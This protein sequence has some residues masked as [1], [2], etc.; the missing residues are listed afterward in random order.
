MSRLLF[1]ILS[2]VLTACSSQNIRTPAESELTSSLFNQP[3]A[4]LLA[5]NGKAGDTLGWAVSLSGRTALIGASQADQKGANAGAA[6]FFLRTD[7]IWT[8]HQFVTAS[9]GRAGDRFGMAVAVASSTAVVGAPSADGVTTDSGAVYIFQS[10][11]GVWR[12]VQKIRASDGASGDQFGYSVSISGDFIVVGA[13]QDDGKGSAYVFRRSNNTWSQFKK[14]APTTLKPNDRFGRSTLVR[15]NDIMIGSPGDSERGNGAG[16][17]YVYA[18]T[19]SDWSGEKKLTASLAKAGDR[20]GRYMSISGDYAVIG[21]V[22]DNSQGTKAGS[23]YV[24]KRSS[25]GWLETQRLLAGD[26]SAGARFGHGVSIAGSVIVVGAP[27]SNTL[28]GAAYVYR[29]S[30]AQGRWI[31]DNKLSA[32]SPQASDDFAYEV[33]VQGGYVIA[34]SRGNDQ[35]GVNAGAAFVF[36]RF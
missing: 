10:S 27:G 22:Y 18:W 6:Y 17:V 34:G 36:K 3:P 35:M 7:E 13:Y 14:L 26:G 16:A 24:F 1:V 4:T 29:W 19:G 20:F 8:Q 25:T 12:E 31:Q 15:G 21:A 33:A 32:P 5:S 28:P 30:P 2:L 23:A 9:D 11:N